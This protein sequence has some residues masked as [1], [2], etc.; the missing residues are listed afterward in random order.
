MAAIASEGV[1]HQEMTKDVKDKSLS[2]CSSAFAT[3]S[4]STDVVVIRPPDNK[5]VSKSA[6][7]K[8]KC[9]D[10]A[11][12]DKPPINYK[13][14][15]NKQYALTVAENP[16]LLEDAV[17]KYDK[18]TR[19]VGDTS[20]FNVRTWRQYHEKVADW[21]KFGEGDHCEALPLTVNRTKLV[22]GHPQGS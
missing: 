8:K 12:V 3:S 1:G 9:S 17:R 15:G 7:M 21:A 19:S 22:R 20:A 14:R 5:L 6:A 18:D 4:S 16:D 10:S 2:S 11:R 13:A